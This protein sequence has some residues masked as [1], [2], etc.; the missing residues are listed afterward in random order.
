M[1]ELENNLIILILGARQLG[2]TTVLKQIRDA[3]SVRFPTYFLNL[4]DP[5]I[6]K[7]L[8]I[9][10]NKLFD[11]TGSDPKQQQVI[12]IDEIQYLQNP[13][14]VLKYLYDEYKD[15]VKLIVSGSS[16]F[17]IDQT[18]K[19]SLMGR[20]RIL[21]MYSLDFEEF[22]AF[23]QETQILQSFFIDKKIPLLLRDRLHQLFL[24]YCT[25]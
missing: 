12:F 5:D 7:Y 20:K 16:S 21:H 14:N 1:R 10:P 23:K 9:H 17:Y 13:S 8:D 25:Y 19:D 6:K 24:E 4:E 2:K 15:T 3:I 18:F 11:I 22:L